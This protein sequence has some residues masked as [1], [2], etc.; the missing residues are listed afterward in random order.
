MLHY[1]LPCHPCRDLHSS[2][3][4]CWLWLDFRSAP[5][6]DTQRRDSQ[7]VL[8]IH[9]L[10]EVESGN[11]MQFCYIG[12]DT[13]VRAHLSESN[14]HW[15][16]SQSKP[17]LLSYSRNCLGR[18]YLTRRHFYWQSPYQALYSSICHIW[19]LSL[20]AISLLSYEMNESVLMVF[21]TY[22]AKVAF[23]HTRMWPL[24]P[25]F[26]WSQDFK[27]FPVCITSETI[28]SP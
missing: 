23:N 22:A 14:I 11:P 13:K 17:C 1:N 20:R 15:R 3:F 24:F 5:S 8:G 28:F 9:S 19:Q 27:S 4:G 10:V 6:S 16:D 12:S 26:L 18:I 7:F 25:A 2:I 21:V